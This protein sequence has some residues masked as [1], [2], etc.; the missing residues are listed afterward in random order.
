MA[1]TGVVGQVTN[2]GR[3]EIIP[4]DGSGVVKFSANAVQ[5]QTSNTAQNPRTGLPSLATGDAVSYELE[6]VGGPASRVYKTA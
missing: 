5:L 6:Q 2:D 1:K 3:G 4:D